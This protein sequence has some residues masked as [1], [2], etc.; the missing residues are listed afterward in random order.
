MHPTPVSKQR[1]CS[2]D[3]VF[4][5]PCT[6]QKIADPK[7][8]YLRSGN[9][10]ALVGSDSNNSRIREQSVSMELQKPS[11]E[12]RDFDRLVYGTCWPIELCVDRENHI[13]SHSF[14][15]STS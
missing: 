12:A 14:I 10:N 2:G 8:P 9:S 3:A 6:A 11:D 15:L 7:T 4:Q 13:N 5:N 1:L